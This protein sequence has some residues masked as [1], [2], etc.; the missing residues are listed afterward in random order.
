MCMYKSHMGA[1]DKSIC[2]HRGDVRSH[3]AGSHHYLDRPDDGDGHSEER[4]PPPGRRVVPADLC[5]VQPRG[6]AR[7]VHPDLKPPAAVV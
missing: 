6:E 7:G 4:A 1:K 2:P 5:E 3:S